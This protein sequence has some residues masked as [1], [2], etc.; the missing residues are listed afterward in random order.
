[1]S[2]YVWQ[3]KRENAAKPFFVF[4]QIGKTRMREN[5]GNGNLTGANRETEKKSLF[6]WFPPVQLSIQRCRRGL[7]PARTSER[8]RREL[9]SIPASGDTAGPTVGLESA[10]L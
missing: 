2:L 5:K 1:M 8:T 10:R 9:N 3:R 4:R 7:K 6:S